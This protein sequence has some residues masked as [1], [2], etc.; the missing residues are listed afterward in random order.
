MPISGQTQSLLLVVVIYMYPIVAPAYPITAIPVHLFLCCN[1]PCL[2]KTTQ[3]FSAV[4]IIGDLAMENHHCQWVN[5]LQMGASVA[6]PATD[7][8]LSPATPTTRTP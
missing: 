5:H 1:V 2:V 6:G 8:S 7:L 3:Q 4:T